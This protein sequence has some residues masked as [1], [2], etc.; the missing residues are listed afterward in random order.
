[1]K[2]TKTT[3]YLLIALA[4]ATILFLI[5]LY[6]FYSDSPIEKTDDNLTNTQ[7][8]EEEI[9]VWDLP[10]EIV[11]ERTDI[12]IKKCGDANLGALT[13]YDSHYICE[14]FNNSKIRIENEYE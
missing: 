5:L 11:I 9:N 8:L 10:S 7:E 2:L 1:M 12:C 14:C 3:K 6:A 4:I 13:M